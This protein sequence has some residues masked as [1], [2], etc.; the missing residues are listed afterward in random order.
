MFRDRVE[1]ICDSFMGSRFKIK[2]LGDGLFNELEEVR[3]T[4]EEDR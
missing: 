4:I 2:D 1:K 3:R